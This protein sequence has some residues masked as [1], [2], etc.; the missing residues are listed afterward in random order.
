MGR[1]GPTCIDLTCKFSKVYVICTPKPSHPRNINGD[2]QV[3]T[4]SS[5][6]SPVFMKSRVPRDLLILCNTCHPACYV[7]RS[8]TTESSASPIMSLLLIKMP[9]RW[10]SGS[11]TVL[12]LLL[13]LHMG[14][15]LECCVTSFIQCPH[16]RYGSH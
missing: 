3:F 2:K 13:T 12:S 15:G 8:R 11:V 5:H 1:G 10:C 7:V 16:P 6:E 9:F 14:S 4:F